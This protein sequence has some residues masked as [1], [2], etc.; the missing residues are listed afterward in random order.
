MKY[1]ALHHTAVYGNRPQLYAVNRY[2]KK[3]WWMKSKLGWYVG[4]NFFCEK[5]GTRTNTREIGEET[6]AN[7]GHNCDAPVRCDTISYAMAG[8]FDGENPTINQVDDF[9][10]FIKEM[11][12]KYP[13]IKVVGHREIQVNRTCPGKLITE[14]DIMNWNFAEPDPVNEDKEK[15][16]IADFQRQIDAIRKLVAQLVALFRAKY[17]L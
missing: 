4:Y 10:S 17:N 13:D 8:N 5:D 15:E 2:H 16:K 9:V 3:K 7:R 14:S 1:I 6:I 12:L 11:K